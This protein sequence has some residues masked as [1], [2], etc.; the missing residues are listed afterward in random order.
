MVIEVINDLDGI[1]CYALPFEQD[2]TPGF[3]RK[4]NF[5]TR[6]SEL[7][8]ISTP[9]VNIGLMTDDHTYIIAL[10]K[11]AARAAF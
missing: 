10:N 6:N 2:T 11:N 3:G 9:V 5:C 7:C 1:G 4:R 8:V